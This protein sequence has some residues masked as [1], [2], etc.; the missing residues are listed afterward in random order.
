AWVVRL[1]P[2]ELRRRL[3]SRD[4]PAAKVQENVEAEALD[5]ILQEALEAQPRRTVQRDGTRR[6]PEALYKSF[7]EVALES[8]KRPDLEPVDWTER[9]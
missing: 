7:A 9:L 5:I 4:Y 3:A 6:S 8:L 1:D 2:D